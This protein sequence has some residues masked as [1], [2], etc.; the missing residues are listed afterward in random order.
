MLRHAL[1]VAGM[2]A[3]IAIAAT[4]QRFASPQRTYTL[5]ETEQLV[6]ADLATMVRGSV[7]DVVVAERAERRW[8]GADLCGTPSAASEPEGIDGYAFTLKLAQGHFEY[9]TDRQ[10]NMRRCVIVRPINP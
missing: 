3:V 8:A 9:R 1:L 2:L 5:D 7:S 6:K 4:A 10:G